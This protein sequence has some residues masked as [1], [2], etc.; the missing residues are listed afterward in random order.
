VDAPYTPT[1]EIADCRGLIVGE[2][3]FSADGTQP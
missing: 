3:S 2:G 1:H